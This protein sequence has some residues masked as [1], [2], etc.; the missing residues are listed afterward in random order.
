MGGGLWLV[1]AQLATLLLTVIGIVALLVVLCV[2][3]RI[4]V[5]TRETGGECSTRCSSTGPTGCTWGG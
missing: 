1:L 2:I 5:R 3:F 4:A